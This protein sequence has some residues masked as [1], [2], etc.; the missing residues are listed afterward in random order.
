MVF[1]RKL[2]D[3]HYTSVKSIVG[4]TLSYLIHINRLS[5]KFK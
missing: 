1:E 3:F 4:K 5:G 2:S